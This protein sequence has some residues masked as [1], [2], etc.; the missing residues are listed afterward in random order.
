MNLATNKRH[1]GRGGWAWEQVRKQVVRDATTCCIC[2]YSLCPDVPLRSK[3]STTVD[4][5]IS[6]KAM[7]GL[8]G[9]TQRRLALDPSNLRVAH[10]HCNSKRGAKVAKPTLHPSREWL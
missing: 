9:E 5:I 8:D 10:L 2:G 1:P 7:R 3:W 4:H 6:I